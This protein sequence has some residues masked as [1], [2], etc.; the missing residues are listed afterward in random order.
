M[1][2][3]SEATLPIFLMQLLLLSAYIP[4]SYI[5]YRWAC[6]P[7]RQSMAREALFEL[8]SPFN[9]MGERARTYE[10]SSRDYHGAVFI[11]WFVNALTFSLSHPYLIE[12]GVWV[13]VLEEFVNIF[14]ADDATQRALLVGRF[15]FYGWAGAVAYSLFMIGRRFLDYD[16]TPRVYVYTAIRFTMAFVIG[17]VVGLLL[18]TTSTAAGV[19]FNLNLATVSVVAFVIGFFPERGWEF[20]SAAAGKALQQQGRDSKEVR[21]SK[22]EGLSIFQ[23]GRLR[24]DGIENVQNL[25]TANIAALI[26]NTPFTLS[27]LAD[28]IDQAILLVYTSDD[29]SRALEKIG[30]IRASD[31]L[32]NTI[33]EERLTQLVAILGEKNADTLEIGEA[34]AA[35]GTNVNV[36]SVAEALGDIGSINTRAL[37]REELVVLSRGLQ[38]ALNMEL[39]TYFRWKTSLNEELRTRLAEHPELITM[40]S[41][42]A[43]A[44]SSDDGHTEA[45]PEQPYSTRQLPKV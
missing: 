43:S 16:L 1:E 17:G 31:V 32:A 20:L 42:G 38:S 22:V 8:D 11:A 29:Q 26:T 19:D 2:R 40:S 21:L 28:W 3:L 30:I 35:V 18:G 14:G 5:T 41:G 13:G 6:A 39:V 24:Q 36:S 33:T 34:V 4:V 9:R 45:T 15:L 7:K 25:A 10:F 12:A 37:S 27:Q 23:Q 44:T